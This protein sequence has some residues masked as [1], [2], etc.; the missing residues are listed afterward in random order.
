M[1]KILPNKDYGAFSGKSLGKLT[2]TMDEAMEALHTPPAQDTE[3]WEKEF[4]KFCPAN[5]FMWGNENDDIDDIHMA[6]KT[7]ESVKDFI[8]NLLTHRDT[9]WKSII[10]REVETF[11]K[12]EREKWEE[13]VKGLMI[14]EYPLE[15]PLS[16]AR[17][18]GTKGYNKAIREFNKR[19]K[20]LTTLAP[21]TLKKYEDLPEMWERG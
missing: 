21:Y 11:I 14:D 7:Q 9:Y 20:E 8:R 1:T 12:L 3:E 4:D 10:R 2:P 13:K 5:L 15:Y 19:I 18:L 16:P 17:E 6:I